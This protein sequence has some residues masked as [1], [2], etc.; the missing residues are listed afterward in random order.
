MLRDLRSN[1]GTAWCTL[2]HDSV[3]WPV[4]GQYECRT[5]GR[6][7]TAFPE[8]PAAGWTTPAAL[9]PVV[10]LLLLFTIGPAVHPSRAAEIAKEHGRTDA[11][12]AL[13]RY[14][15]AGSAPSWALESVEIHAALPDLTRSGRLQATRRVEPDGVRY[16][17]VQLTGDRT[18]KDQVIARYLT[19]E[20]RASQIPAA[21]VAI[22]AAN[23]KFAYKGIIND[24]ERHAYVFRIAPRK[25]RSGLLKG[26]LWLDVETGLPIRRSGYLVKSPSL[27]IRRVAVTQEDSLHDGSVASRLTHI[28]AK[29]RLAGRAELVITERPLG[30]KQ[31]PQ[32]ID[33]ESNVGQQ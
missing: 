15:G 10:S 25:K 14:I 8:A 17:I 20:E 16:Q 11:V 29:T 31:G 26:E 21:S 9:K 13:E 24:G 4:H 18:V 7:Y 1:L 6:H 32:T 3:M 28:T 22:S 2:M 23:Y 5:C 12:A 30:E 27:W 19:A 33:A